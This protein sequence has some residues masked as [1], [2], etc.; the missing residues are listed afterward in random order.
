L[1]ISREFT[2]SAAINDAFAGAMTGATVGRV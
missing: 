2:D 1:R